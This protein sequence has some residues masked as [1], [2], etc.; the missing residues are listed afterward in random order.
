MVFNFN[1]GTTLHALEKHGWL[2]YDLKALLLKALVRNAGG[3][4]PVIGG[5]KAVLQGSAL[6]LAEE[7]SANEQAHLGFLRT[8][9]GSAALPCPEINIGSAFNSFVNLTLAA[10]QNPNPYAPFSPYK[11]FISFYFG[12]F[13]LADPEVFAYNGASTLISDKTFLEAAAGILAVEGYHAGSIRENLATVSFALQKWHMF[14]SAS[15]AMEFCNKGG[16]VQLASLPTVYGINVT[17]TTNALAAVRAALQGAD[18]DL[19]I[20]NRAGSTLVDA[21]GNALVFSRSVE[22]SSCYRT[23][24]RHTC[25]LAWH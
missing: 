19:G 9:L 12:A 1:Y 2:S 22:V 10:L 23:L 7:F 15:N 20:A 3:G 18:E 24:M 25:L 11:E 21:D 13:I 16:H 6:Q 4:G 8:T 17:T 14:I 5:Q